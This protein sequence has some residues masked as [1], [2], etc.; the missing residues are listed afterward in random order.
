MFKVILEPIMA[1][2]YPCTINPESTRS[3]TQKERRIIDTLEPVLNQHRLV[4][5]RKVIEADL[6]VEDPKY[7]LFYQL[8]RLTRDRGALIHDDRLD[9]LAGAV[10][11]WQ[12][13]LRKNQDKVQEEHIEE[14]R[15]IA[16]RDFMDI[17]LGT[18][19]KFDTW[20]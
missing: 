3:N 12:E 4:V 8:T 5:D 14:L 20:A 11:Y 18:E 15:D 16:L 13:S 7:S 17:A 9:A 2:I 6:L 1:G 10:A 19:S